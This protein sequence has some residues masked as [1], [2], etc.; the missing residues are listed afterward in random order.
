MHR[1]H[2]AFKS[3]AFSFALLGCT[4]LAVAA[5]DVR[6]TLFRDADAALAAANT[7]RA[8]ILAPQNYEEAA[9]LYRR[10]E[11]RLEKGQRIERIREDLAKAIP[12]FEAAAKAT[13]LAEVTFGASIQA[14]NDAEAAQAETY[15]NEFWT[16]AEKTFAVA[17]RRLESGN[18]KRAQKEAQEAENEYRAAELQA[19]KINYLS[20]TAKIIEQAKEDKVDRYAP[21]TLA[22]AESQLKEAEKGLNENRYDTDRPR[23]L[24]KQAR[25]QAKHAVHIANI[26]KPLRDDQYTVEQLILLFETPVEQI[27]SA[28]DLGAE[29]DKGMD[30]PTQM[31][32][33]HIAQLQKDSAELI[34]RQS[35]IALLENEI[36]RLEEKMGVQSERLANQEEYR[37]RFST[38]EN[39]FSKD[40]AMVLSQS[41]NV[42]IRTIGLNFD[43]GSAQ[44]GSQ[45][46][47]LLRKTQQAIRQFPEYSVVIEGH[48]DSFGS[49]DA[50]LNLSIS[51]AESV[52]NYLLANMTDERSSTS[53]EAVGY[54]ETKPIGN[55]ETIEGRT[56]N[57]R[58]DVILMPKQ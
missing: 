29:F 44:I 51:R 13:R 30:G 3:I 48:T 41:G 53:I 35:D 24:A 10:A 39:L 45:Y 16:D 9:K 14:R 11:E 36:Q 46:F 31:I 7:A 28:L 42:V 4:L 33:D 5:D 54:G 34:E 26:I 43:P 52:R 17:A 21:I 27:A 18:L 23:S 32:R 49:D 58:I 19:I 2:I 55:N 56:K 6:E 15:A 37:R 20:E 57:R 40:E 25:Y 47:G 38:L 22:K 12:Y 50:N 1:K 8:N